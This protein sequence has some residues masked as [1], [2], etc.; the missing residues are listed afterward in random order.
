MV[1]FRP[2][3]TQDAFFQCLPGHNHAFV[4]AKSR[5][6]TTPFLTYFG[7]DRQ[8]VLDTDTSCL[9]GLGFVLLQLVDDVWRPVQA[10]SGFLTPTKSRFVMIELKALASCWV[11]KKCNM[12]L[13]G[14]HH[15]TLLTDHKPLIPI[16]NSMGIA[17]HTPATYDENAALLFHSAIGK[18]KRSFGR[19]DLSRFPVDQPSLDDE[20]LKQLSAPTLLISQLK[21]CSYIKFLTPNTPT[22]SFVESQ[23]MSAVDGPTH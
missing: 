21:T 14:L 18:R 7:V 20:L 4:E 6:S 12:F 3:L 23:T 5:L 1:P 13:Q 9:K 8:T 22:L 19:K 10:G 2:I 16:L 17:D 11:M 15:F